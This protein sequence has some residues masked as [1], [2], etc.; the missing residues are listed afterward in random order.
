MALFGRD[1][2]N[3]LH[4]IQNE[5]GMMVYMMT[6]ESRS[7]YSCIQGQMRALVPGE[8]LEE[9]ERMRIAVK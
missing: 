6:R 7:E 2:L 8:F 3:L 4:T 1:G 5:E 9:V